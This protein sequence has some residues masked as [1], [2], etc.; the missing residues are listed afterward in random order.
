MGKSREEIDKATADLN[1]AKGQ[2]P[3]GSKNKET[4]KEAAPH[5]KTDRAKGGSTPDTP[6]AK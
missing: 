6:G 5:D 4:K 3:D 1:R 2:E